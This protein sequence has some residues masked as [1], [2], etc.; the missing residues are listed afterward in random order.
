VVTPHLSSC[1]FTLCCLALLARWPAPFEP[2]RHDNHWKASSALSP[3][4]FWRSFLFYYYSIASQSF[5]SQVFLSPS[6]QWRSIAFLLL[7]L[8]IPFLP[9]YHLMPVTTVPS[10]YNEYAIF[11]SLHSESQLVT[12]IGCGYVG[13]LPYSQHIP[14]VRH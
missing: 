12:G 13:G 11:L 3:R 6:L 9:C 7:A 10:A 14:T 8:S 5:N 2:G 1:P 4:L